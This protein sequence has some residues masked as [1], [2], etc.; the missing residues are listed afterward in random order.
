MATPSALPDLT[1]VG[2]PVRKSTTDTRRET[3]LSLVE[4]L[5]QQHEEVQGLSFFSSYNH[6]DAV[7]LG[8]N[9]QPIFEDYKDVREFIH[10]FVIV[11]PYVRVA[12]IDDHLQFVGSETFNRFQ[13]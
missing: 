11:P 3:I 5:L 9:Q 7:T 1:Q 10:L 2:P 12:T 13:K 8:L 6:I 4:M